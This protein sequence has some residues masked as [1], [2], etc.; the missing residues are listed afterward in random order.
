RDS[1]GPYCSDC[2]LRPR[3]PSGLRGTRVSRAHLDVLAEVARVLLGDAGEA[4]GKL[5]AD[6]GVQGDGGLVRRHGHLGARGDAAALRVFVGELD[7]GARALELQLGHALDG[8]AG[9][10]RAV[11]HEA[12][13]GAAGER[14]AVGELR[15]RAGQ[16]GA[17]AQRRAFADL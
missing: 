14:M 4:G 13:A 7:L 10:E 17:R 6:L 15:A 5:A 1:P 2:A 3:T 9:E 16:P 11:A 8:G 12:Q